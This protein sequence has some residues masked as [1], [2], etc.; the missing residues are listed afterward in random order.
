MEHPCVAHSGRPTAEVT[1]LRPIEEDVFSALWWTSSSA[2]GIYD[3]D[4]WEAEASGM[5]RWGRS[6]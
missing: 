5:G 2:L 1:L 6:R 4:G 3:S